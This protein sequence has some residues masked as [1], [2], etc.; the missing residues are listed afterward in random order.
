MANMHC[1]KALAFSYFEAI[2][3]RA[4]HSASGDL[5]RHQVGQGRG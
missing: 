3:E 5:V 2:E 1:T 4:I